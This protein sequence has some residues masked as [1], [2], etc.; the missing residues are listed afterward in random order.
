MDASLAVY[1]FLTTSIAFIV[2]GLVGFG[3]PLIS[4]PLLT[5][6]LDNKLISPALLPISLVLNVFIVWKNR[7]SF[8]AKVVAPIAAWVL[9]GL[10][11]GVLLLKVGA[12]D[13][14]KVVLG[15]LIIGLGVEMFTRDRAKQLTPNP[16]LKAVMCFLSGVTAGLFG[17]NMLFMIY[18]ERSSKGRGDFRANT[19]FVFVLENT[20]RVILYAVTGI[21]TTMTL[22]IS[23][24]TIPAA[25][26]GMLIGGWID[27]RL[28]EKNLRKIVIYVFI[29]GGVSTLVK[30]LL[31][32]A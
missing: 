16:V 17:I 28:P 6:R 4:N 13:I 31:A 19:C 22:Q 3:D 24:V 21:F 2:K 32:M 30:A 23:A 15:L 29:L 26:C 20:C 12:P 14:L 25:A 10:V 9:L 27:R 1:I 7:A 18:L 5:M 8:Q 11:P